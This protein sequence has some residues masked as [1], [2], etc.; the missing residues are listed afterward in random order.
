L[1]KKFIRSLTNQ[2]W[3]KETIFSKWGSPSLYIKMM[4]KAFFYFNYS[5]KAG[6]KALHQFYK[7]EPPNKGIKAPPN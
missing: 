2:A 7:P 6:K 4:H 1:I 3:P 5:V